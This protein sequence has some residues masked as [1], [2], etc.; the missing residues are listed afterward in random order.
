[1]SSIDVGPSK[2]KSHRRPDLVASW[3]AFTIWVAVH[4]IL[5]FTF[6]GAIPVLWAIMVILGPRGS[7][8]SKLSTRR[9]ADRLAWIAF[10]TGI[11]AM[12][13]IVG[14]S[15]ISEGDRALRSWPEIRRQVRVFLGAGIVGAGVPIF[16]TIGTYLVRAVRSARYKDR[17]PV[18]LG[19]SD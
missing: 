14:L 5:F 17:V 2:A 13:W 19:P 6:C 15:L 12:L 1:M 16:V 11:F 9:T 3:A 7:I 10:S 18:D 8:A 4:A